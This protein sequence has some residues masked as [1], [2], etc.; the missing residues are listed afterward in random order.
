M[1]QTNLGKSVSALFSGHDG[2]YKQHN[3]FAHPA[4]PPRLSA[5]ALNW[6]FAAWRKDEKD[7]ALHALVLRILTDRKF[8]V[9]NINGKDRLHCTKFSLGKKE[10]KDTGRWS[11]DETNEADNP[12]TFGRLQISFLWRRQQ[13]IK[14]AVEMHLEFTAITLWMPVFMVNKT[15]GGRG[16]LCRQIVDKTEKAD[17]REAFAKLIFL[18]GGGISSHASFAHRQGLRAAVK[19]YLDIDLPDFPSRTHAR[20][21]EIDAVYR[22]T[23]NILYSRLWENLGDALCPKGSPRFEPFAEFKSIILPSTLPF[24]PRDT[25]QGRVFATRPA[26]PKVFR[27]DEALATMLRIDE[28]LVAEAGTKK[29]PH[30]RAELTGSTF[31][32]KRAVYG[33]SLGTPSNDGRHQ[34]HNR[35]ARFLMVIKPASRWQLGRLVER[36]N[37]LGT[38]RLASLRN[39]ANLNKASEG[40]RDLGRDLIRFEQLK[41]EK[42]ES[43]ADKIKGYYSSFGLAARGKIGD[44]PDQEIVGGLNYRVDRS[45]YYV[46][47]FNRLLPDLR[48]GRIEGFQPYHEFVVRRYGAIWDRISRVGERYARLAQRLDFLSGR[49][50]ALEQRKQTEK[51]IA[52]A[53]DQAKQ[54][55]EQTKLLHAAHNVEYLIVIYYTAQIF[56]G[57]IEKASEWDL[58]SSYHALALFIAPFAL[59]ALPPSLLVKSGDRQIHPKGLVDRVVRL[60]PLWTLLL[61]ACCWGLSIYS[62]GQHNCAKSS[63]WSEQ[64]RMPFRDMLFPLSCEVP[65]AQA[66]MASSSH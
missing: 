52:Q 46:E 50:S 20:P 54:T 15:A 26:G 55:D 48:I 4:S 12:F 23:A 30:V 45:R 6:H 21:G 44:N 35:S 41:V 29:E 2:E 27:S 25:L 22:D 40:M 14:F 53:S 17:L 38:Y 33:S 7:E 34:S 9:V 64:F 24:C 1:K 42:P 51:M 18:M 62:L 61:I 63:G 47:S 3:E 43:Y 59:L 58:G 10:Y 49:L 8:E 56:G 31:L 13:L 19:D 66:A 36:L 32:G 37:L 28:F 57:A 39:L 65:S 11:A 16:L 60:K 5:P